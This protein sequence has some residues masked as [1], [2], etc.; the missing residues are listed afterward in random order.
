VGWEARERGGPYYTRSRR[1]GAR[2]VRKYVG[3]GLVGRLSAEADRIGRER[4]EAEKARHRRELERLE[5]LV[6]P[7]AELSE[8]AEVLVRAELLAGGY[9]RHK[10]EWRRE[11]NT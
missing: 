9:H 7:A 11:R 1:V 3:G 4:A 6:S 8:A 2:V 10:G 5:A